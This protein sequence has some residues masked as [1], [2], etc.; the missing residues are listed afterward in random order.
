MR[1]HL[2]EN[3]YFFTVFTVVKIFSEAIL[4]KR[5]L[6]IDSFK[7][8]L[9]AIHIHY[10]KGSGASESCMRALNLPSWS[11][12]RVSCSIVVLST[13]YRWRWPFGGYYR[14]TALP[15]SAPVG[16]LC[17][18]WVVDWWPLCSGNAEFLLFQWLFTVRGCR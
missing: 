11:S 1:W 18:R 3:F 15:P 4:I 7:E 16:T 5:R 2:L 13:R 6:V 14:G 10:P 8:L 17:L 12:V 9:S